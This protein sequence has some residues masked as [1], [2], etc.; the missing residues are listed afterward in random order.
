MIRN[1]IGW[2]ENLK[3][4]KIGFDILEILREFNY[5]KVLV[6]DWPKYL[7]PWLNNRPRGIGIMPAQEWNKD[8]KHERVVRY[9]GQNLK[10][11]RTALIWAKDRKG[12]MP[13]FK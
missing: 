11:V 6:D 9:T 12:P 3:P 7:E 2:W 1:Q 5:G 4:L 13:K 10:E 8:F